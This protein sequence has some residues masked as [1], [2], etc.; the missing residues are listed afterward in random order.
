MGLALDP[1]SG[2]HVI[3]LSQTLLSDY[4]IATVGRVI[5]HEL[6]HHYREENWP[7]VRSRF[8]DDAH[9]A[10]FA[11]ELAKIDPLVSLDRCQY[12]DAKSNELPEGRMLF[13]IKGNLNF[14]WRPKKGRQTVIGAHPETL[15]ANAYRIPGF[16]AGLKIHLDGKVAQR[17]E[18]ARLAKDGAVPLGQLI[19][20]LAVQYPSLPWDK[21][22]SDL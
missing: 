2:K 8:I 1:G 12:F 14:I 6:C 15:A 4:D 20:L 19:E 17:P 22:R 3:S 5:A 18:F 13:R 9:D 21:V 11:T 7:R 16:S 10:R